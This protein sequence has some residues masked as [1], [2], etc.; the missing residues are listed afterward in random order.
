MGGSIRFK[1]RLPLFKRILTGFILLPET[2]A[3]K[4]TPNAEFLE[5]HSTTR[6]AQG[7][8]FQPPESDF[9]VTFPSQPNVKMVDAAFVEAGR[10]RFL[11]AVCVI[12][13]G[14][15]FLRAEFVP[16]PR[17][18]FE[19]LT[20]DQILDGLHRYAED[21]GIESAEASTGNGALGRFGKVRGHKTIQGIRCTYEGTVYYGTKSM[22]VVF[23]GGPSRS[24]PQSPIV[25]FFASIRRAL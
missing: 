1:E 10:T 3:T 21:N 8:K 25:R 19:K 14:N 23:A 7:F 15:C 24:Y 13:K 16:G 2:D 5:T 17:L 9:Y 18:L 22:M 6:T 4:K 11:S 12:E 20:N